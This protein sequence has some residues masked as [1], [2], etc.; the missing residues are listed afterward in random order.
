MEA[1][2]ATRCVLRVGGLAGRGYRPVITVARI[3]AT[4][5]VAAKMSATVEPWSRTDEYAAY[6]PF[7]AIVAVR[8]ATVRRV[9]VVPIR[10]YW[11]GTNVDGDTRDIDHWR[12]MKGLRRLD[13]QL[14]GSSLRVIG[15]MY[16]PIRIHPAI[17]RRA[18]GGVCERLAAAER[19]AI[20]ERECQQNIMVSSA[21]HCASI[22][23]STPR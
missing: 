12:S 3:I 11:R 18:P 16:D 10:T 22:A 4:V 1:R 8:R 17:D 14:L 6:K 5:D 21:S 23:P 19:G 7:R 15:E 2:D 9:L 13:L 20:Q